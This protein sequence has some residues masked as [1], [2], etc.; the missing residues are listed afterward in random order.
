[1][2]GTVLASKIAGRTPQ[3]GKDVFGKAVSAMNN[4]DDPFQLGIGT[5]LSEDGQN[6]LAAVQG[7]PR[8][9]LA[10]LIAVHE[11]F[12]IDGDIDNGTRLDEFG[13]NIRV[14][15]SIKSGSGVC[16]VDVSA[17]EVDNGIIEAH[18][19]LIVARGINDAR[20]YVRGNVYA[21]SIVNSEIVCM[22]DVVVKK[23]ITDSKIECAGACSVISGGL[24]S[25]RVSAKMGLMVQTIRPGTAGPAEISVGHDAFVGRELEKNRA[26]TNRLTGVI[27]NLDE[28]KSVIC[29]QTAG[30]KKQKSE[31]DRVRAQ[32]LG[33]YREIESRS[34]LSLDERDSQDSQL[35]GLRKELNRA[36]S[37][38]QTYALKIKN[39]AKQAAK[40]DLQTTGLW[41]MKKALA[42]EK[43][44]LIRWSLHTPGNPRVVADGEIVSGTVIRGLHS[45]FVPEVDYRYVR[46]ME[47]PVK[48]DDPENFRIVYQMQVDEL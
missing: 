32:A 36:E 9:T 16:G 18:G 21:Q 48:S 33:K 20:V 4:P 39:L 15:G 42:D 10:G 8:I 40:I 28:K 25:G 2:K 41:A 47:R 37:K 19:D 34:D 26:E 13:C 38:I 5:V 27:R 45:T 7:T 22:G 31:L 23:E 29:R 44:N 30:F 24:I 46:I 14:S 35:T 11:E 12:D 17:Q 1:E 3:P 6:V 43:Q